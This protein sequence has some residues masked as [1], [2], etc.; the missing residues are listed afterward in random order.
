VARQAL[1]ARQRLLEAG[2]PDIAK[3]ET[4]LA[5]VLVDLGQFEEARA[6]A[7]SARVSFEVSLGKDHWRTAAAASVEGAALTG[8]KDYEAAETLLVESYALLSANESA[9]VNRLRDAAR[10]LVGLYEAW[11]RPDAA[12]RYRAEL[13]SL[14]EEG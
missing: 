11:G 5:A 12:A 6:V 7:D 14:R 10:W 9:G 8:L 2:H 3:T 1:A 4:A 13:A